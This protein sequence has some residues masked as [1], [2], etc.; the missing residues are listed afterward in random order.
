MSSDSSQRRDAPKGLTLVEMLIAMTITLIMMG[1]VAQLF[2]MMGGGIQGNRN[3]AELYSR[4]RT[5]AE[6]L[7]MDLAG[8][9]ATLT[10][11]LDPGL[12]R[13]FFEYIEGQETDAVTFGAQRLGLYAV[14][15]GISK[16]MTTPINVLDSDDRMLGDVDDVLLFTTRTTDVAFTGYHDGGVIE[17]PVAEVVWYCKA[18]PGTFNPRTFNVYRRQRLVMAHPAKAVGASGIFSVVPNVESL[19]TTPWAALLERTDIS[20]R[21]QNGYAIPNSLGDLT[22]RENRFCRSAG[23]PYNFDPSNSYLT[24][25]GS[26]MG[27][28]VILTNC[29]GFD[30]RVLDMG[31]GV[32]VVGDVA[33]SSG[34]PG[35]SVPLG[36]LVTAPAYVDLVGQAGRLGYPTYDTWSTHYER[37]G[38]DDDDDSLIDEGADEQDNNGNNAIDEPAE[39]EAPPPFADALK[40]IE[41]RVRCIEPLSR[42][43]LQITVRQ[44][45]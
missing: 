12:S 19:S 31:A 20:C 17:S 11:P 33:V 30:V 38:V 16:M 23:P 6:R 28:D 37:N 8:L 3:K 35:F 10:P 42:K 40:G 24:Y 9:T 43:I 36:T 32:R 27:E 45:F 7:K 21:I 14:L 5:A 18:V 22:K 1:V 2:A 39:A 4:M 25:S 26:R 15:T 34:D 44:S 29:I 13:G 41:V